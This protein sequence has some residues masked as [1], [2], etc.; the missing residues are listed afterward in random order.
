[1]GSWNNLGALSFREHLLGW[2]VEA[3]ALSKFMKSPRQA[4]RIVAWGTL[5]S[6][7]PG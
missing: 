4:P 5:I 3:S 2:N 7:R 1:M 6:R